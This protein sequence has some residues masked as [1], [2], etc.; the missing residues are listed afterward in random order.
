[1]ESQHNG[2]EDDD[3]VKLPLTHIKK[4]QITI[5]VG[6]LASNKT[7]ASTKGALDRKGVDVSVGKVICTIG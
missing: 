3:E 4:V 7:A 2:I 5:E 6:T 1:M